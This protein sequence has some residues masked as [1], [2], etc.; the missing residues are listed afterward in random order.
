VTGRDAFLAG[1][2]AEL[3]LILGVVPFGLI[4][5]VLARDARIPPEAAVAMS[6]II[7]AG[8]AQ[9]IATQLFASAAP[10]FIMLLTA[11][12]VNLRHVLYS[13]SLAPGLHPLRPAWRWLLAYLLTDEAYAVVI[14]RYATIS[15]HDGGRHWF[16]LGA[17]LTLWI[18]WLS[19]S[20]AGVYLG[21]V[22]PAGWNLEF[23]LTLI[24]IA[25]VVPM[26]TDQPLVAAAAAGGL[27][28]V[29]AASLPL[30]LGLMAGAVAGITAGMLAE[31]RPM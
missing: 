19:S 4:Y 15:G 9:F 8:S 24:F 27:V 14:P 21:A 10:G 22:V 16:F 25:I 5:G 11:F 1:V 17:G 6:A 26:V 18:F 29:A 31:R 23:M 28:A 13:A 7:F 30:R 20:A 12:V 3:P 2:K